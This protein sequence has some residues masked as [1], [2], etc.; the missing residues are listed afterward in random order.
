[1]LFIHLKARVN[2]SGVIFVEVIILMVII[3]IRTIH[4]LEDPSMLE[5]M[6]KVEDAL[7]KLVI[8][9]E[10]SMAMIRNIEI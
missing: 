8:M 7:T 5:R 2:Q 9:K 6:S 3:L 4:Q 10:N 1:M